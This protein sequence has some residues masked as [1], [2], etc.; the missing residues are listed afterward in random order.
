MRKGCLQVMLAALSPLVQG[1]SLELKGTGSTIEFSSSTTG[2]KSV[3]RAQCEADTPSWTFLAPATMT[4]PGD[5][6]SV[7]VVVNFLNVPSHCLNSKITDPC[8][9]KGSPTALNLAALAHRLL[10]EPAGAQGGGSGGRGG[11]PFVH[12]LTRH[13][14]SWH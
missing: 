14:A 9:I 13:H 2:A 5:T 6:S 1:A 12:I 7:S 4:Y 3:L 11:V 8:A 10:C